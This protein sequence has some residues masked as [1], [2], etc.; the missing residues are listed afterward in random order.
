LSYGCEI[1]YLS[2]H[3]VVAQRGPGGLVA[4]HLAQNVGAWA[5]GAGLRWRPLAHVPLLFGGG[6]TYSEGGE[7]GGHSQQYQQTGMQSNTSYFTGTRTLVHRYNETLQAQLGNLLVATGFVSLTLAANDAS[8]IV[9]TFRR[10]SRSAPFV[11]DNLTAVPV[12]DDRDAGRGLDLVFTH[13]LQR[14]R[15]RER[16]LDRGDAFTAQQRQSLISLHA[17]VF[18][19]GKAYGP[20][21]STDYRIFLEMTLWLD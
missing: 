6:Y 5:A 17:S 18:D 14:I 13:Y 10:D 7:N 12:T 20:G 2:G 8:L 19:P 15:R 3:Q 16:L 21:T 9:E 1:N 11:S 4:A